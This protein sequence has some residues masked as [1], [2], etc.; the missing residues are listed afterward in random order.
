MSADAKA[1]QD[2]DRWAARRRWL[3]NLAFLDRQLGQLGQLGQRE[4]G[5][6]R[7]PPPPLWARPRGGMGGGGAREADMKRAHVVLPIIPG[8]LTP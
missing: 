1:R 4:L 6:R 7:R 3:S 5:Q 2:A 8:G